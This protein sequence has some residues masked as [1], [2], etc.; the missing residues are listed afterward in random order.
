MPDSAIVELSKTETINTLM[1]EVGGSRTWV[2]DEDPEA[3]KIM[4]DTNNTGSRWIV[5][6]KNYQAGHGSLVE[7]TTS[8]AATFHKG[9][10]LRLAEKAQEVLE[11]YKIS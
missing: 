2:N 7:F 4:Y 1:D 10:D 9:R 6:V 5:R 11:P 8:S 3:I